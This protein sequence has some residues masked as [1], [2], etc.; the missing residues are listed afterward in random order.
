MTLAILEP[1][2]R[3]TL[4]T[5]GAGFIGTNLADRLLRQGRRVRIFDSLARPGSDRNLRWLKARHGSRLDAV[6]GDARSAAGVH[7]A[8]DDVA[9]VFHFA[10]QV[11]VTTSMRDP[12]DE[13][14]VTPRAP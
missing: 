1:A 8:I 5:G 13:F 14:E 2:K 10:A 7:A 12:R 6:R 3:I 9:M 4:I 11:A